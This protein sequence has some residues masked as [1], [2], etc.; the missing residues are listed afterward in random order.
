MKTPDSSLP[1]YGEPTDGEQLNCR[2]QGDGCSHADGGKCEACGCEK[3][4]TVYAITDAM[5]VRAL[6]AY[7][8]V[9]HDDETDAQWMRRALEEAING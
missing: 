4:F 1:D 2:C 8:E 9:A 6:D 5:V 7:Q 3:S